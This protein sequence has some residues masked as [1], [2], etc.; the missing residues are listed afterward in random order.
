[1]SIAIGGTYGN[2]VDNFSPP[3]NGNAPDTIC[4]IS[5][6]IFLKNYSA[7]RIPLLKANLYNSLILLITDRGETSCHFE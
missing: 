1:M 6:I 5:E 2:V 3:E 4:L 7:A